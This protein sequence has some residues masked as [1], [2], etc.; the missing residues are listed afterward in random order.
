MESITKAP[1]FVFLHSPELIPT[2][3]SGIDIELGSCTNLIGAS[4]VYP[5]TP[6]GRYFVVKGQLW[7]C[8]NPSLPA[9]VRQSLVK[10][11]IV[12]R[13]E[14]KAAK[15]SSDPEQLKLA[16]AHVKTAKVAPRERGPVWW[17]DESLGLNQRQVANS[18]YADWYCRK[19]SGEVNAN[20]SN[21]PT[22]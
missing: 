8:N 11:L 5:T 4:E 7:R 6:Y 16:T 10:E 13:R 21:M 18:P 3:K 17:H 14:V 19:P 1:C 9:D 15:A 20:A 22:R 2:E 12:A